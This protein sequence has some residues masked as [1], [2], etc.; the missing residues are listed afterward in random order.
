MNFCLNLLWWPHPSQA[1]DVVLPLIC[2]LCRCDFRLLPVRVF[3]LWK[4]QDLGDWWAWARPL[5]RMTDL[6]SRF[7]HNSRASVRTDDTLYALDSEDY[8]ITHSVWYYQ[9]LGSLYKSQCW[10]W[11]VLW[12]PGNYFVCGSGV[13]WA[14]GPTDARAVNSSLCLSLFCWNES[15]L[16]LGRH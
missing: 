10:K 11:L 2:Q 3:I 16:S 1:G 13:Q 12:K 9:P 4:W 7:H 5:A 8:Q 14:S 15:R 6:C